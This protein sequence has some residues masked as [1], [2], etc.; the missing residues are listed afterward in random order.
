MQAG[1]QRAVSIA[2]LQECADCAQTAQ[3]LNM[4]TDESLEPS[5]KD[6]RKAVESLSEEICSWK[7]LSMVFEYASPP[8]P[9]PSKSL[10]SAV[11]VS[12][13]SLLDDVL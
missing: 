3:W 7:T 1:L 11:H 5:Q 9:L 13:R 8:P 4:E 2:L 6:E 12:L 10:L